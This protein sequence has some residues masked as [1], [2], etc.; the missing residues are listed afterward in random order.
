MKEVPLFST[1]Q[2][3]SLSILPALQRRDMRVKMIALEDGTWVC[4]VWK[5]DHLYGMAGPHGDLP[6]ALSRASAR[7]VLVDNEKEEIT[8]SVEPLVK[9]KRKRRK[10]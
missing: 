6:E 5:G 3:D 4:E 7:A 2:W 10:S 9:K 1:N 8:K